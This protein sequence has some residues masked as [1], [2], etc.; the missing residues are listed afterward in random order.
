MSARTGS[1]E[2]PPNSPRPTDP[3]KITRRALDQCVKDAK[4][5][6]ACGRR[7]VDLQREL[8]AQTILT[9]EAVRRESQ[10]KE[11]ANRAELRPTWGVAL[12]LF[13][14]GLSTGLCVPA[15][16]GDRAAR[17]PC[18]VSAAASMALGVLVWRW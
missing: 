8:D 1:T 2:E 7:N 5:I 11:R 16:Q 18:G 6:D 9:R 12:T 3:V 15:V 13:A 17:M 10:Q 14:V 4:A